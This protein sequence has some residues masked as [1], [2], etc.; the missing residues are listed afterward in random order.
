MCRG[1]GGYDFDDIFGGG[2]GRGGRGSHGGLFGVDGDVDRGSFAQVSDRAMSTLS[3]AKSHFL[4]H[5]KTVNTSRGTVSHEI[6]RFHLVPDM[7]KQFG[8][9]VK[10]FGC[11]ATSR[12]LTREEQDR[13]NKK[14]K[15]FI[16]FTSVTVT[17]HA[18]QAYFAKNPSIPRP[19]SLSMAPVS[20]TPTAP[21]PSPSS[22]QT[23]ASESSKAGPLLDAFNKKAKQKLNQAA[24]I[25]AASNSTS[26]K[27]NTSLKKKI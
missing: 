8:Q 22:S 19:A 4:E 6:I 10:E 15:S 1:C 11:T 25:H 9:Y 20:A 5:L 12:Q 23:S 24:V 14:R 2:R 18:Q 16:Y 21:V 3:S 13:I 27:I 26:K 17:H 7:R